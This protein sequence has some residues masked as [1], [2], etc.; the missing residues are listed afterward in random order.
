ME[1]YHYHKKGHIIK[2]YEELI[3]YLKA[4]KNFE[5]EETSYSTNIVDEE[6]GKESFYYS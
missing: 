6:F 1:C 3:K 5:A 4:R 2:Y